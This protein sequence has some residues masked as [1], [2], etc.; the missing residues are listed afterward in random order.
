MDDEYREHEGEVEEARR[1]LD[2]T[3]AERNSGDPE[4]RRRWQPALERLNEA[5]R[6]FA[7]YLNRREAGG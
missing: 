2:E 7:E 4:Q 5:F 3:W 1:E 6:R